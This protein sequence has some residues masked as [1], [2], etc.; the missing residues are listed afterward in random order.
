MSPGNA[1]NR[2]HVPRF[3]TNFPHGTEILP[4]SGL[5]P[6]ERQRVDVVGANVAQQE[7]RVVRVEA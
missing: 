5:L 1:G 4:R 2:C 7:R 3:L 6:F